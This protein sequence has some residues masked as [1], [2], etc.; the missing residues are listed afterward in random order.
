M[1]VSEAT[2]QDPASNQRRQTR[3]R[4]PRCDALVSHVVSLRG[5]G[6]LV[7]AREADHLET[8]PR[9]DSHAKRRRG[10]HED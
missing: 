10:E 7:E 8:L 9:L 2:T 5:A 3:S 6:V 4:H 1:C